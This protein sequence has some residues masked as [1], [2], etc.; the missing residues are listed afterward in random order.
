MDLRRRTT[1]SRR[2]PRR[3]L[4]WLFLKWCFGYGIFTRRI[5]A[6]GAVIILFFALLYATSG[7][8]LP[9]DQWAVRYGPEHGERSFVEPGHP[10]D[11]LC[12]AVYFSAITFATVGY[13]DWYPVHWARLAA[14]VEGLS[15]IFIMSVFTVS[16]ARKIIR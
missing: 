12:N 1:F 16:F 7:L 10:I 14:A 9:A 11:T 4:D 3:L 6:S 2:S 5:L 13:G 15:G 8:G